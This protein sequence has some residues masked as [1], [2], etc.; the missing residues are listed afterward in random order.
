MILSL[1]PNPSIDA[2]AWLEKFDAGGVNRINKVKEYPGGKGT[3]VALALAEIG[4]NSRL[5][6]AWAGSA[7]Q[8][9]KEACGKFEVECCGIEL[10]GNNRKC[11]TFRSERPDF[12]NSELLEPGPSF[13][14]KKWEAFIRLFNQQ[15][16]NIPLICMSGSWPKNA[17]S[18]AYEQLILAANKKNISTILDC[19]GTQLTEALKVGFFGLHLNEFEAENLCGSKDI[20]QLLKK[21]GNKVELVALTKGKDGLVLAYKGQIIAANL[22]LDKVISTVG[23]GDCLTA[24]IAHAISKNLS[25][26][27]IAAYTVAC[28]AANCITEDLGM[29]EKE[30]VEKLLPQVSIKKLTDEG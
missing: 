19:S 10:A 12:D 15:L 23:S 25:L 22:K 29:L 5:M 28:G 13:T 20:H 1:C 18:D 7:G 3:H 26:E 17:P 14:T 2:Y 11:F 30:I 16:T 8:W 4:N 21:I 6:G 27:E 9:I 24:G